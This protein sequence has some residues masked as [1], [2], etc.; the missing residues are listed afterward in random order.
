MVY[1]EASDWRNMFCIIVSLPSSV[2]GWYDSPLF[3]MFRLQE[4]SD[5]KKLESLDKNARDFK[6][7]ILQIQ[8]ICTT[9]RIF[10]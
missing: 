1:L 5:L 10:Q 4:I 2:C 9:L 7:L 6:D 8:F 3:L